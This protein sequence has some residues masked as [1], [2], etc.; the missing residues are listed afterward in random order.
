MQMAS[1]FPVAISVLMP[2]YNA[3]RY[4]LQSIQSVLAQTEEDFELIVVDDCSQDST[5]DIL[6]GIGD[7]RLKVIRNEVNQGVVAASNIARSH[8][9]GRYI[10]RLDSDDYAQPTR[11]RSQREFLDRHPEIDLVG[12]EMSVLLDGRIRFSRPRGSMDPM[13]MRW[14][15]HLANP[16]GHS[17]MMFRA[18]IVDRLGG[19]MRRDRQYAEDFDFAHRVLRIGQIA[20]LPAYLTIYRQHATNL[21][22]THRGRM[23]ERA[24]DVLADAYER[25]FGTPRRAEAELVGRHL[26]SGEPI[27]G[28]TDWE[29]LGDFLS[30]LTR[31]FDAVHQPSRDQRAANLAFA[32][33]LWNRAVMRAVRNGHPAP[34][35]SGTALRRFK[36]SFPTFMTAC[37]GLLGS[38][39]VR[40]VRRRR[41][42]ASTD[43]PPAKLESRLGGHIL[44]SIPVTSDQPPRLYVTVDTEAEFDWDKPFDS[45]ATNVSAMSSQVLAQDVF[46]DFGIRPVYVMDYS[47]ASRSEGYDFLRA[48]LRR[49]ACVIGAHLHP[50]INPPLEEIISER[51]SLAANLPK[52]LEERKLQQLVAEIERNLGVKPLFFKSGRYGMSHATIDLLVQMGFQVDLSIRP[53]TS[54]VELGGLDFHELGTQPYRTAEGRLLMLPV[55][56]AQIGWMSPLPVPYYRLA[57]GAL[58][59]RLRVPGLLARIG[60]LNTVSLSPEGMTVEEQKRLI[61]TLLG[62]GQRS[63]VLHYHSSTLGGFTPY[64]RSAAEI[65]MFLRNL[66]QVCRF[67]ISELGGMAGNPADLV[68]DLLRD[69]LWPS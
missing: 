24:T 20:V 62:R 33:S 34:L 42:G 35:L 30:D 25:L 12:T 48:T 52:E 26:A 13:T 8:A 19:Y 2:A 45:S 29:R 53:L 39:V 16:L 22:L 37:G 1:P 59:R 55:T 4:V 21:T 50:W 40:G 36:G 66:E 43:A 14:M 5:P 63:F 10:A 27:T 69:C 18:G 6:R 11:F 46:D 68:P 47:V 3:E 67:F 38:A 60:A 15:L 64:A 41:H 61:R 32:G 65:Q 54:L 7:R 31:R 56:R 17:T 44:R 58:G 51:N 28:K 57:H 9:R 23:I 49:K